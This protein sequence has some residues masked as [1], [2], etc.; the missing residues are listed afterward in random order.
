LDTFVTALLNER[1]LEELDIMSM[2]REEKAGIVDLSTK[3]I[4]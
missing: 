1:V 2:P 4:K 3:V